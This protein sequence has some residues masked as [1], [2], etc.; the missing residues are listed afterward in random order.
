MYA[1]IW[2]RLPGTKVAK[3]SYAVLLFA[4]FT[5]FM[6]IVGFPMLEHLLRIDQSAITV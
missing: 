1:W 3:I 6:F 2:N 5:L 4:A